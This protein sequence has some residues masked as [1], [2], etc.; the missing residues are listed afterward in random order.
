MSFIHNDVIDISSEDPFKNC[1]LGREVYAQNLTE[2]LGVYSSGFVMSIDNK[3][4]DGKTTFIKMWEAKL[5]HSG[6][7]TAY[8]NSWENDINVDPFVA[9]MSELKSLG[10]GSNHF[11]NLV[12]KAG[13]LST[14]LIPILAK[15]V[16]SKAIGNETMKE[17]VELVSTESSNFLSNQIDKYS[18]HKKSIAEFKKE[19]EQY[20]KESNSLNPL[21][22][23]VDEL[24]RCRPDYAVQVLEKI[25]HL[26]S[27]KGIIFVLSIDKEQLCN[28]I[29]GYYGSDRINSNEYLRRFIDIEFSLPS[30]ATENYCDYLYKYYNFDDFF[31][32]EVRIK[33]DS[34]RSSG[35]EFLIFSKLLS[36]KYNLNL[37]QISKLYS[38]TN[39][40][41]RQFSK[42]RF[43]FSTTIY[44]LIYLRDSNNV[45][46]KSILNKEFSIQ[47]LCDEFEPIFWE[48]FQMGK[49]I[50]TK[51]NFIKFVV[52]YFN[53]SK[54]RYPEIDLHGIHFTENDVLVS[55]LTLKLSFFTGD[56]FNQI[57]KFMN[58][59]NSE[60]INL[61]D[62]LTKIN[63][64][65][66]IKP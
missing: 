40:V 31:K 48:L 54:N 63:L 21:I 65:E 8:F 39:L 23:F 55:G 61:K 25:K 50:S 41:V 45:K 62:F 16:I 2:I 20:I 30:P 33:S 44:F 51:S 26:F 15:G 10:I 52:S 29:K 6:Y 42:N 24:D 43:F 47:E 64:F 46:F 19:L 28:S 7:Q 13:K 1:K 27:V 14:S 17:L 56:E 11:E 18:E 34:L 38:H 59:E 66:N 22:F 4:G 36:N 53:Y 49:L 35:E 12:L 32:S 37:R 57:Y 58:R 3:W 60:N 5:K 9:I